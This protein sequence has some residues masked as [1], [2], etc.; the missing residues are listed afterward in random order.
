MSKKGC[1]G[2]HKSVINEKRFIFFVLLSIL[3]Y[4]ALMQISLIAADP[5]EEYKGAGYC[6]EC[7]I[8]QMSDWYE[9]AHTKGYSNPE[10]QRVWNELGSKS[11]CLECHTTGYDTTTKT[12]ELVEVQ[13]EECHG[14]KFNHVR[15]QNLKNVTSELQKNKSP[16]TEKNLSTICRKCHTQERDPEFN[17]EEYR[18]L[19]IH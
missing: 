4:V 1:A 7:H 13:C 15:A 11:E 18:K 3:I 12:Y 5:Q 6:A 19:I 17:Y 8:P 10:F 14:T 9:S 16:K 2:V